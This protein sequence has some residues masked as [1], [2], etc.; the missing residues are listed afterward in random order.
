M[1]QERTLAG[2]YRL[3]EAIGHG[4]MSTV[5]CATDLALG[6][7]VAV[8]VLLPALAQEDPT[9]VAR[10]QREARAAAALTHPAMVTIFDTGADGESRYIVMEL[11]EGRSVAELLKSGPLVLGQAIDVGRAVADALAGAH[12]AGIL[13]R[14]V[15]PANVM[16]T[17]AGAVKV[18]DFGVARPLAGATITQTASVVGT[19]AYMPPE[20]VEGAVGDARSDVY[21]LGCLLYAM[22]AGAPPFTGESAAV[23]LHQHLHARPDPPS[24]RR[25]EVSPALDGLVLEMLAK[26]PAGRPQTAAEVAHRLGAVADGSGAATA[27]TAPLPPPV[28]PTLPSVPR[29]SN[30]TPVLLGL[31]AAAILL[32]GVIVLLAGGGGARRASH[33]APPTTAPHVLTTNQATTTPTTET[34]P[35]THPKHKPPGHGGTPPGQ[36]NQGD[37][38][39]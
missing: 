39:D 34:Q 2:R 3:D 36:G 31:A 18:L 26:D 4:G 11:V 33:T 16:I 12:A 29:S 38:G 25:P 21:S 13:H 9:Y 24:A 30:R 7:T 32:V 23:L 37:G 28:P 8:K 14:D 6:R 1:E 20:R 5:Y 35:P 19:A 22:L 17:P 10:F 15:K 27:A